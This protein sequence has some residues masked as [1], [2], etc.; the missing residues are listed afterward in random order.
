MWKRVNGVGEF[1]LPLIQIQPGD[2]GVSDLH[3]NAAIIALVAQQRLRK[4]WI[5][6]QLD[7]CDRN[8]S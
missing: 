8:G 4:L 1:T 6:P 7:L 5:L 3:Q 2:H